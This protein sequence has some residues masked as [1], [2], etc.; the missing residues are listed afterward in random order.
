MKRSVMVLSLVIIAVVFGNSAWSED[1]TTAPAYT[2]TSGEVMAVGGFIGASYTL[3]GNVK[4]ESDSSSH[5]VYC[6]GSYKI[7]GDLAMSSGTCT[8]TSTNGD[9]IVITYEQT[10]TEASFKVAGGTGR[11]GTT[12]GGGR[13][14]KDAMVLAVSQILR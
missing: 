13:A 6:T 2:C 10:G 1:L 4:S 14:E 7:N 9:Q 11:N 3:M 12:E 8:T 5:P